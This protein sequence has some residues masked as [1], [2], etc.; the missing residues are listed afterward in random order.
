MGI[1]MFASGGPPDPNDK[2]SQP[3]KQPVKKEDNPF[4]TS[5]PFGSSAN[6]ASP[7][8]VD[9]PF[10]D[11]DN[12]FGDSVENVAATDDNQEDNPFSMFSPVDNQRPKKND[13][14]M[15]DRDPFADM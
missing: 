2:Q 4:D 5:N 11:L 15:A 7:D 8:K 3:K 1:D 9:N 13:D 12:P 14:F 10:E 6:L